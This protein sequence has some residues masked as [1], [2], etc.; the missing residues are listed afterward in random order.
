[1]DGSGPGARNNVALPHES[2]MRVTAPATA[3]DQFDLRELLLMLRRRRGVILSCIIVI[4]LL[5]VV[6]VFQLKPKYTAETSLLLDSRKTNIIDLQA[7]MGGLQPEAA[8]IR[9]EVDVLRSRQLIAK[10][11]EKL[12]LAGNPDF[13]TALRG[14]ED[15]SDM[16]ARWRRDATT[17]LA[18]AGLGAAEKPVVLTPAEMQQQTLMLLTDKLLDHLD[19]ALFQDHHLGSELGRLVQIVGGQEHGHLALVGQGLQQLPDVPSGGRIEAAG[20]LVEQQHRRRAQKRPGD[21][22]PAP[23]AR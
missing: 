11:I 16:L 3:R 23:H 6:L 21:A 10:V 5:A 20:R 18:T 4:T 1:M 19:R 14:D 9:S 15:L 12:G 2:A 22:Q 17:W 13:N 8:A 7:V